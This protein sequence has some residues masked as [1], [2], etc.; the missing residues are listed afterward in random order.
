MTRIENVFYIPETYRETALY[1][2]AVAAAIVLAM[3]AAPSLA[4]ESL[5]SSAP[6][7]SQAAQAPSGGVADNPM[8]VNACASTA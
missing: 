5:R 2:L 6:A 8:R 4:Q 1:G 7:F 3:L